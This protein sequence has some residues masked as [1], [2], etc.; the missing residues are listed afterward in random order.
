PPHFAIITRQFL[1][2]KFGNQR[3]GRG[4]PLRYPDL[5]PLDFFLWGYVK[6]KVMF[7]S[8]T[9]KEYMKQRIRDA[10]ASVTPE[11]LKNFRTTLMFRV[12]KC[13]QTHGGHFE[14]LI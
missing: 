7:E 13:L 9:T 12:N 11:M 1:N 5:T 6:D 8:P 4:G 10:C 2:E 14:H 3:I